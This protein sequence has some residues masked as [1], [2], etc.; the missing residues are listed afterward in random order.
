ML[1][2]KRPLR[3]VPDKAREI[4]GVPLTR[5]D[6]TTATSHIY[7]TNIPVKALSV[8]PLSPL[9]IANLLPALPNTCH[10][11]PA[12]RCI[13]HYLLN[14][15]RNEHRSQTLLHSK[16]ATLSP[17]LFLQD[18]CSNGS[19]N[20]TTATPPS[21]LRLNPHR[22]SAHNRAHLCPDPNLPALRHPRGPHIL[23]P[24][25]LPPPRHFPP[26]QHRRRRL[27]PAAAVL[28]P[29][30]TPGVQIPRGD[31]AWEGERRV[32][33]PRPCVCVR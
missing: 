30:C 20:S 23:P 6:P 3:T 10:R 21:A 19:G 25:R 22:S 12:P 17:P 11:W 4:G 32:P 31:W 28:R 15:C 27:P 7:P 5:P 14:L 2:D 8:R 18:C 16:R 29:L 24:R 9:Y 26:A 13:S 1:K 33:H